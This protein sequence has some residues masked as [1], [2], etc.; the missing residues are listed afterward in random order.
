[1]IV[2]SAAGVVIAEAVHLP[3]PQRRE[4]LDQQGFRKGNPDVIDDKKAATEVCD[5]QVLCLLDGRGMFRKAFEQGQAGVSAETIA[6]L[7]CTSRNG[8]ADVDGPPILLIAVLFR[9]IL[10][11]SK[12]GSSGK[13]VPELL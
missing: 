5:P 3:V 9:D 11:E 1:M 12:I 4:H 2:A 10:V 6:A 7:A 8:L 13:F